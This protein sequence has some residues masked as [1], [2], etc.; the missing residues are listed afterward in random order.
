MLTFLFQWSIDPKWVASSELA[1]VVCG[2]DVSSVFNAFAAILICPV[3]VPPAA[4]SGV[5]TVL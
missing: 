3:S 1:S 5:W 4:Q 2:W